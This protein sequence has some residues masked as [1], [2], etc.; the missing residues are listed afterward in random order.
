MRPGG[1]V[2]VT[3]PGQRRLWSDYDQA[4]GHRR[5]Y[6]VADLERLLGE[7]GFTDVEVVTFHTWLTPLTLLLARTP[8]RHVLLREPNRATFVDARVNRVLLAVG[9]LERRVL[10]RRPL[11]FGQALVGT[12]RAPTP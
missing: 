5:R 3:V 2:V 9:W 8:L 12:G 11:S 1:T 4:L 10:R 7:A 6:D